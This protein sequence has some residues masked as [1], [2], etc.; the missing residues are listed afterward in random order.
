MPKSMRSRSKS[1]AK[2]SMRRSMRKSHKK[3]Q[4][5][6][7]KNLKQRLMGLLKKRSKKVK[8]KKS[9]TKKGK[10]SSRR[11]KSGKIAVMVRVNK[12]TQRGGGGVKDV[13]LKD[14]FKADGTSYPFDGNVMGAVI[15]DGNVLNKF[16]GT[17]QDVMVGTT[18]YKMKIISS[19][20][21]RDK[22]GDGTDEIKFDSS[23]NTNI[24]VLQLPPPSPLL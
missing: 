22:A 16:V 2:K 3:S 4:N 17:A 12:K 20:K 21:A 6:S 18:A 1:V 15:H 5:K 10:S 24:Q 11:S 23:K 13:E 8:S 19:E 7:K 14:I 9:K